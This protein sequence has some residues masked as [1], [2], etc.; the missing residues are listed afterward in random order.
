MSASAADTHAAAAALEAPVSNRPAR[1]CPAGADPAGGVDLTPH[2]IQRL[3][4]GRWLVPPAEPHA[5]IAG[6]SVDSREVRPGEAFF[7]LTGTRTCGHRFVAGALASGAAVAVVEEAP[8]GLDAAGARGAVLQVPSTLDALATLARARR[9]AMTQ[10]RFVGVTGSAGKTTTTRLLAAVLGRSAPACHSIRSYNNRLGLSLTLLNAPAS[11]AFCVCEVGTSAPGEIAELASML[12]PDAAVITSVGRAHLEGLGSLEGVAREKSRLAHGAALAAPIVAHAEAPHLA[13]NLPRGRRLI[14]FG[15]SQGADVRLLAAEARPDR[16]ML[17]L[18]D[19]AR[20]TITLLGEHNA[21]NALAA[22]ALARE[23]G[24]SDDQIAVGLAAAQP[25]EM[26]LVRQTLRGVTVLNDAYN[27][28]PESMAAALATLE[29]VGGDAG[30]RVAVLA[31]MLELGG[32]SRVAHER[33]GERLAQMEGLD[34]ALLLG[35]A[36]GEAARAARRQRP[37]LRVCHWPEATEEAIAEAATLLAEGDLALLKGSRSMRLERIVQA[38]S[39][40]G[41]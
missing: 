19:G 13:E 34:L 36:M 20:F 16:T 24:L 12:Q 8:D 33:L 38:L 37:T 2:Q 32:Q 41:L 1:P 22:I 40:E 29:A 31:D 6:A 35:P 39:G 17:T 7:A 27:A 4:G 11:S 10:T 21:L 25:P 28:N 15:R 26:R 30:R 18:A 23:W 5:A 3:T 9:R 14:S